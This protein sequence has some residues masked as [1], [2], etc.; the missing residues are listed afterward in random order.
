MSEKPDLNKILRLSGKGLWWKLI[1]LAT[2]IGV[3]AL[4]LYT[5]YLDQVVT[6]KFEGK[7][8]SVPS[9][10]YARAL[11][12]YPQAPLT[13]DALYTELKLIGYQP[14]KDGLTPGSYLRQGNEFVIS[15]R[16]FRHWDSEEPARSVKV[17][18]NER[19]VK[20][21]SDAISGE[22]LELMRLEPM[23]IGIIHPANLE[24]RVLV[25]LKELPP[26]LPAALQAVED[27]NFMKH[28]G[29]D[30]RA[31]ARAAWANLR[32][33]KVVQG[34]S[35]LT[36]QLVKNFF[37]DS[38]RTLTRK[39][40]EAIM[41]LL[42]E[43]HYSKKEI[44]E[45]YAN[46][47]YLGQDGSRAIHGFG[48]ASH[49]YFNKPPQEL[50][51]PDA[52]LLVAIVRGPTYYDPRRH[53]DRALARRNQVINTLWKDGII[54]R[55]QAE[56]ALASPL[57]V[58]PKPNLGNTLYPAFM[59]L[60]KRQLHH[61]YR[62]E[63]LR[64]EGLRIFTTLDPVV[65]ET[66]ETALQNRIE[67]IEQQRGMKP[68]TLE[69]GVVLTRLG[70]AEVSAVVGGRQPRYEGFNRA[71]DI[72][73][74]VGSLLKPA[75]YLTALAQPRQYTLAS[76]VKDEPIELKQS[77]GNVWAPSNYEGVSHGPVTLL[78]ALMHS[79]NQAAVNLGLEIGVSQV[80]KTINALGIHK[81]IPP[82]PAIGFYTPLRAV[83]D[84]LD[85]R[86]R[87]LQRYPLETEQRFAPEPVYLVKSALRFALREGTGKSIGQKMPPELPL[88]G[89][90]GTTD[91]LRDS[92]F[93]GFSNDTLAVVW[94]GN[95]DNGVTGLTGATGALPVWGDIM[96]RV[97]LNEAGTP[98]PADI[99][100]VGIDMATGLRGGSACSDNRNVPF[101]KG[102]A[103]H[104]YAPCAGGAVKRSVETFMDRLK[105]L[106]R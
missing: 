44:L 28:H 87:P 77:K 15:T 86:H 62:D 73:R 36:Q 90:T 106:F 7:R 6:S 95:D 16:A 2:L 31:I 9:R 76:L 71:L 69:G 102:S 32:A 65:Q 67:S 83:R 79:Y 54:E 84:V 56:Q 10:V 74:P 58:T 18:I 21:L 78:E 88:A 5:V 91:D 96:R 94:I 27:R 100:T 51:L 37:L 47:I 4:T 20:A 80:V 11:E 34:G 42:L 93:A 3:V 63:D 105:R 66:A 13:S 26:F 30:F 101:I 19:Q 53:P 64:S 52:A 40:N 50:S 85:A 103:P 24:D 25:Q 57:G 41:S 59:E 82:Y 49:F 92:W 55:P 99:E 43:W 89:K 14:S 8:W 38:E 48:L 72:Q 97:S 33:G 1:L 70:S 35:T 61:D 60:V 46:E 23:T 81:S 104:D 45:A 75:L 98:P 22:P 12:L 39:F 17:V 29:L 68:G